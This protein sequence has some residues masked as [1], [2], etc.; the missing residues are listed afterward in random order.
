MVSAQIPSWCGE[1][2]CFKTQ[3]SRLRC[4]LLAHW[5]EAYTDPWL[6]VTDLPTAQACVAWYGMRAWIEAGFKDIKRGGW[7]W[8]QTKMT[9]PA[10]V[11][12]FWLVIAVATLWVVSVGA[13]VED[14]LPACGFETLPPVPGGSPPARKKSRPRLLSCF[15]RGILKILVTLIRGEALPLGNFPATPWLDAF[16]ERALPLNTYP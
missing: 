9:D 14:D 15:R 13:Q 16:P 2:E 12:R 3:A 6:I 4:T 8:E 7:H 5:D 1:V 11:E 10:R